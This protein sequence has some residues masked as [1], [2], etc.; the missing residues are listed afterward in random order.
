MKLGDTVTW[1]SSA[2]GSAKT[3]TGKIIYIVPAGD[4]AQAVTAYLAHLNAQWSDFGSVPRAQESYLILVPH[5]R[6]G[7]PTL[8]WPRTFLLRPVKETTDGS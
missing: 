3:K 7:K 4:S 8:Y 5:P 2:H 6:K 1:T